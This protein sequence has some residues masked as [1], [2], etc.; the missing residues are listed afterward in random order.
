MNLTSFLKQTDA[1]A[2]EYSAEQL[3]AFIHEL[4]RGLPECDREDFLRR[5]KAAGKTSENAETKDDIQKKEFDKNYRLIRKNLKIIDSQEAAVT[6]ILNEEYDDWYSDEDEEFRYEDRE[7]ISDMLTQA[8]SF[9]HTCMDREKYKEGC[10]IGEQLFCMEILCL[11]E[12]YGDM[13]FS[14]Q[15]MA[16]YK[17]LDYDLKQTALDTAYCAY[18]AVPLEKRPK[19][20]YNVIK[21]ARND[22]I[23]LEA[24]MQHGEEEL[25]DFQDFL[26]LWIAFLGMKED[27]D[28][29]R[30]ISE[31][32]SLLND[33]PLAAEYAE[34][35]VSFHPGLYLN[36]LK[37]QNADA[38]D[39]TRIGMKAIE[40]MPK[41]Y[42][43]R[44]RVAL[45]TAAYGL[46]AR[47][48]DIAEKCYL[49][50]FESDTCAIN[51]LRALF[52][53]YETE[54]KKEELR[55]LFM[56]LPVPKAGSSYS[57]Y[58]TDQFC[59]ARKEN[60]PDKNMILMLKFL[61]GQFA[62]VLTA[63]LNES[64]ALG[65]TGTFMKQG[66]AL[67]LLYL[68]EGKNFRINT[69]M[70][71]MVDIARKA[72]NFSAAE[73]QEGTDD[74]EKAEEKDFFCRI[75]LQWKSM[76]PME[77]NVKSRAVK[78]I[79]SLLEKRTEGIIEGN[80]RSYYGEC[81]AYIA[82]LGEVLEA[83]GNI[84]AKQRLMT[85]YKDKY[86]RRSAFREEMRRYGWVDV[87]KKK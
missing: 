36:L 68:Y 27:K 17:L 28:A 5:L 22:E 64:E 67:Y 37:G 34:K 48:E 26:T 84:D 12:Y 54:E 78:K 9:V 20:V 63:G 83:L 60:N 47:R 69:G 59:A 71:A 85:S 52:H 6:S 55:K 73:Y 76:A 4:G 41:N 53:G 13:E 65:W 62:E 16:H 80:H 35:Y 30:L 23:T 43:I 57:M 46:K 21:N 50:A 75:F 11:N 32:V 58:K 10:C 29:D 39:M 24:V 51:Y 72:M 61:D 86:P 31:A 14:I 79:T 8:C 38:D 15:D 33:L 40:I 66:I 77:E 1:A 56:D 44:S 19:A 82:A 42:M 70:A 18:H 74:Q 7:G 87:K 45:K 81:A 2:A 3:R 25:P 49:A